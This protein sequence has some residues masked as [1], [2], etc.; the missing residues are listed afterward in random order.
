MLYHTLGQVYFKGMNDNE[1]A[2]AAFELAKQN[3][4]GNSKLIS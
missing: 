1:K 2:K 3:C 4:R